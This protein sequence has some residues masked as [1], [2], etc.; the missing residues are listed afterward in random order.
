VGLADKVST[1]QVVSQCEAAHG[2]MKGPDA[3]QTTDVHVVLP[4]GRGR[5]REHVL[6]Q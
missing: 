5:E 6:E 1:A 4:L 3:R 2:K